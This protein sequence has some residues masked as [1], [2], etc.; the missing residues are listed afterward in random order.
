[1]RRVRRIRKFN[2]LGNKSKNLFDKKD[3]IKDWNNLENIGASINNQSEILKFN[4]DLYDIEAEKEFIRESIITYIKNIDI[5]SFIKTRYLSL[6]SKKREIFNICN[7]FFLNNIVNPGSDNKSAVI[8]KEIFF[9]SGYSLSTNLEE[10][11]ITVADQNRSGHF[12]CFGTTRVGKTRLIENMVEDDIKKGYDVIV[13]DPKGDM[14]LLSKISKIAIDSGRDQDLMLL[15]PLYPDNSIRFNPLKYFDIKEELAAHV[16]AAIPDSKEPF[17]KNVGYETSINTIIALSHLAKLENKDETLTF[18]DIKKNT[19]KD[20]LLSLIDSLKKYIDNPET[21][22]IVKNLE[23]I[24]A[25]EKDYF[26]KINSSLR[27]ALTELTIGNVGAL[28]GH[29][30]ENEVI[31]RLEENAYRENYYNGY[32]ESNNSENKRKGVILVVQASSL[33]TDRAARSLGKVVI[34]TMAKLAGRIFARGIKLKTPLCLYIDEAQ[35]M[36]YGGIEELFAKAGGA[37]VWIHCF[38]QSVN[39]VY[40]EMPS[41]NAA[42]SILDNTNTKV[43]MRAPDQETAEYV[44]RYFG[45][46]KVLTPTYNSHSDIISTREIDEKVVRPEV[47]LNLQPREFYLTTYTGLYSGLVR[48]VSNNYLELNFGNIRT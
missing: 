7:K 18:N 47:I 48:T 19:S 37:N 26:S 38:S 43:F 5:S 42:K 32:E 8:N 31:K 24:A 29:E 45:Y 13:I 22:E 14:E 9:G 10:K 21:E 15:N 36:L 16:I 6:K 44:S 39:Q 25:S 40:S 17:F 2:R 41:I 11:R 27:V 34:S 33:I 35:S 28:I 20:S 4:E 23:A 12:W 3:S 30:K 46:K 1:M